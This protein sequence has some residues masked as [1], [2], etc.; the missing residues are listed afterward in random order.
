MRSAGR[1]PGDTERYRAVTR[2]P[3]RSG[4]GLDDRGN[5]P[6][7]GPAR[8]DYGSLTFRPTGS[9]NDAAPVAGSRS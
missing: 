3:G 2:R 4:S 7:E 6:V 5:A 1:I 8:R 9:P